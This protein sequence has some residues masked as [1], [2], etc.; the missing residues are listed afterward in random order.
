MATIDGRNPIGIVVVF[1]RIGRKGE[2]P[3]RRLL[4][5]PKPIRRVISEIIGQPAATNVMP[6]KTPM[7]ARSCR[8]EGASARQNRTHS[9][10]EIES[11]HPSGALGE[12]EQ[13]NSQELASL[14]DGSFSQSLSFRVVVE[15]RHGSCCYFLN[16]NHTLLEVYHDSE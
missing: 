1:I 16:F 15:A 9:C 14:F 4:R 3:L 2:L 8:L 13:R 7:P 10:A 6:R 5:I 12:S 11:I